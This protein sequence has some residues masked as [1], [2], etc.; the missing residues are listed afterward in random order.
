MYGGL[1]ENVIETIIERTNCDKNSV[2]L[3]VGSGI[4]QVRLALLSATLDEKPEYI[5][6]ILLY[7]SAFRLLL[8]WVAS[9]LALN[10]IPT[11]IKV[12]SS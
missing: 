7:R 1:K 3:D 12:P 2:F 8:P 9:V 5:T 10:W 6:I 4:G 11:D